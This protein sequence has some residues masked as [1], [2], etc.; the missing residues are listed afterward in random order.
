MTKEQIYDYVMK[1]PENTNPMILKGML[2][3]ISSG[4]SGGSWNVM[5]AKR[6][7]IDWTEYPY[8]DAL[9]A[10][11]IFDTVP[12]L[13]QLSNAKV[14][15]QTAENSRI[16][17]IIELYPGED[18]DGVFLEDGV[19]FC[20]YQENPVFVAIPTDETGAL[21]GAEK[22]VYL[23]LDYLQMLVGIDDLISVTLVY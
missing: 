12:T 19:I 2:D 15:F 9:R 22:G 13:E 14:F 10:Y 4:E 7:G 16:F 5:T 11:R 20:F 23:V 17:G 8:S 21:L 18:D 1:S 6:S 3:E